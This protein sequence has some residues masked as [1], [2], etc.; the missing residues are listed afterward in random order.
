M[1][2]KVSRV[3][4]L[5]TVPTKLDPDSKKF[6]SAVKQRLELAFGDVPGGQFASIAALINSGGATRN[7]DGSLGPPPL[8]G[9][10]GDFTPPPAPAHVTVTGGFATVIIT[11]DQPTYSNHAYAE[12][13]RSVDSNLGHAV[14]IGQTPGSVFSDAVG[15]SFDGWYWVRF[16]S[17][18]N[19]TG[20]VDS[21][22]GH[23]ATTSLDPT[24]AMDVLSSLY[25]N[26]P[27]FV[28][29]TTTVINGV[30]VPPGVYIRDA[31][32]A[33]GNITSAKI[34]LAQIDNARIA[35]L[36]V[37]TAN[38]ANGAI[39]TAKIGTAQITTAL[40]AAAQITS[41]LIANGTI[42][43]ANIANGTITTA[44]IG[45]GQIT[46]AL[47]SGAIQSNATGVG[48]NPRWI[49]DKSGGLSLFGPVGGGWMLLN[50]SNIQVFNSSGVLQVAMGV[51][52]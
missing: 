25:G 23:E 9:G 12:I 27:F 47:I 41:A 33:N 34:G 26:A 24:Y 45:T 39:T 6:L 22:A 32:M 19:I 17:I 30:T 16:V 5:G 46:N 13:L 48:G 52:I 1:T 3:P 50:D 18:A 14:V 49:L 36:A 11:F 38:I 31:Y 28:Q 40:I 37:A 44:N 7:P 20:P 35:N 21:E 8:P 10:I 42:T 43:N 51:G 4:A 15:N 2:E 29:A